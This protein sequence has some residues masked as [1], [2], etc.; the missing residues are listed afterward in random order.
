M[1]LKRLFFLLLFLINVTHLV[2][3][4]NIFSGE[5][6]DAETGEKISEVYITSIEDSNLYAFS[7]EEGKFNFKSNRTRLQLVFER[8]GYESKTI[9]LDVNRFVQIKLNPSENKLD[10]VTLISKNLRE[11]GIE[12]LNQV[13]ISSDVLQKNTAI[14]LGSALAQIDGVSF[15]STGQNV[16]LPVIHGLYGNRILILN[17]GFKHGFQNWGTDH[18]PEID[19]SGADV[20][21]VIKGAAGV[22]YG[23]DAL[24]GAVVIEG[25]AMNLNEDFYLNTST[26]YQTNGR[27]YGLNTSFGEGKEN[28]SYHFGGSFNVIGDRRAPGY[29]LT[30]TGMRD[31][32]I[33]GGVRYDYKDWT[34]KTNYSLVNQNLGILRASIGSSGAALIRNMESP[35]PTF[36]RPFSYRINEPNQEVQHQL[37]SVKAIRQ[38]SDGSLLNISYARQ[39]NARKEF[40]VRRNA[41]LPVLDLE[42]ETD[43]LQIEWEH[44]FGENISGS[45]GVQYFFQANSNNPGTLVTPFIPNYEVRRY[46]AFLLESLSLNKSTWEFGV[47]YDFEDNGVGGRDNRNNIFQDSFTFSNFSFSLGNVY[48]KSKE[49]KFRN[50][51]GIG[52]RPPNM[53]E[54][55][56][57]GQHEAQTT[58][59]LLRYQP[60]EEHTIIAN[61]VTKFS[62]SGVSPENS[63]KYTSEFEWRTTENYLS[64]SAY[65][66]YIQ[67]FIFSRPIGVLGTA[68]GPMPTFIIDQSDALFLGTDATYT[69]YYHKNGK[70]SIGGSYIWTRNVE[71]NETLINQ[72]PIHL[73]ASIDHSFLKLGKI[74]ELDLSLNPTYTFRQFQAPRDISVRALI[75]G[76]VDLSIDDPIFDFLPPPEGYFLLNAAAGARFKNLYIS[77]EVRNILNTNYRDYLNNMRYFADEMGINFILTA[78]YSL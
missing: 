30:N 68:R 32:S 5:I 47:R 16:Q 74:D 11:R 22:K 65:A 64:V 72:P 44:S 18:A 75:E 13:R 9:Q 54:L 63:I 69:R 10:E 78:S 60:S 55:Y 27:G 67:N 39:W 56:S 40:D 8:I 12:S 33:R 3:Q 7:D 36:I 19:I 59:G 48:K 26:T 76:T 29:N 62:E 14:Q 77:L 46:S 42:L 37:A 25:N 51:V 41:N 34:F 53:A 35:V 50:N 15:I 2:A 57:F 52:W 70:A 24:G 21:K 20:I 6:L 58:F 66:N 61:E 4:E 49:I 71:R 73:H 28:I 38:F 1:K 31:F 45:A 43:D 17:N 23:P